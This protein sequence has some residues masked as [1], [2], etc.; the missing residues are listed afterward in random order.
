MTSLGSLPLYVSLSNPI[1]AAFF[2]KKDN[3]YQQIITILSQIIPSVSRMDTTALSGLRMTC[4]SSVV[5]DTS[6]SSVGSNKLSLASLMDT[7]SLPLSESKV[8]SVVTA[9]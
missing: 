5:S 4:S 2:L 7:H 3:K 9:V 8:S 6:N 1:L